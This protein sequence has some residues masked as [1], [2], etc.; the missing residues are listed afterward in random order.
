MTRVKRT[1]ATLL[2][3]LIPAMS[4]GEEDQGYLAL[5]NA[6]DYCAQKAIEWYFGI[7]AFGNGCGLTA[8]TVGPDL[9]ECVDDQLR[10]HRSADVG[11]VYQCEH[12]TALREN[13]H[14]VYAYARSHHPQSQ[15]EMK[16]FETLCLQIQSGNPLHYTLRCTTVDGRTANSTIVLE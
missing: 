1:L 16:D 7:V 8:T 3:A 10:V 12:L 9:N 2:V 6:T 11:Q 15:E 13:S 14:P 5:Q 4:C